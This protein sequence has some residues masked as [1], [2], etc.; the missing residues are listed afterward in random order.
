MPERTHRKSPRRINQ[1]LRAS[2]NG[3][4]RWI[5]GAGSPHRSDWSVLTKHGINKVYIVA[6]N[7][8]AGRAAVPKIACQLS[9][10]PITVM[11]VRFDDRFP[12]GFDLA[13]EFPRDFFI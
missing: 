6:D 11:V 1:N 5:G 2:F 9:P 8:A 10:Y 4:V 3:G 7:D 13:D 12:S